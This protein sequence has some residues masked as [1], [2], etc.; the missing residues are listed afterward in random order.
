MPHYKGTITERLSKILNKNFITFNNNIN[1]YFL[2][3]SILD[4]T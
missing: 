3:G 4:H 1:G 2:Y